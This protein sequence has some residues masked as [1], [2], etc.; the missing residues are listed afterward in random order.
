MIFDKNSNLL[1]AFAKNPFGTNTVEDTST[2]AASHN[3]VFAINGDYYGF[4]NDSVIIR[5]GTVCREYPAHDGLALLESGTLQP[6]KEEEPS[7]DAL[8]AGGVTNTS[9]PVRFS[10]K[11]ARSRAISEV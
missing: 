2:I 11:T 4:R 9:P 3:A 7:S 8:L 1:T 6:Y 5:N 10:S